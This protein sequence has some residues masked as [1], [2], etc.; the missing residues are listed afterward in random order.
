MKSLKFQFILSHIIPVIITIPLI[1][2]A[3][4]YAMETNYILKDMKKT[5]EDQ[6]NLIKDYSEK[7]PEIWKDDASANAFIQEIRPH[8]ITGVILFDKAWNMI[9][10]SDNGMVNLDTDLDQSQIVT[11]LGKNNFEPIL[12]VSRYNPFRKNDDIIEMMVPVSNDQNELLGIVRL[13]FPVNYFE[14]QLKQTSNRIVIILIC[15]ILL[16]ITMGLF[17]AIQLEKQ[18]KR[19]TNAIYDLSTGV[20]NNPLPETGSTEIRQLSVAFNKLAE[21]L[22]TSEQTRT[23]LISYLT[24]ELGRP[25]GALSSAVDS[26]YL[27]ASQDE[28]LAQ[29]LTTGMKN[30]IKRLELLVGDLSILREESDP[31]NQFFFK[32]V[33]L[34]EWLT[35][36]CK[37]WSEFAHSNEVNLINQ[38]SE[39]LPYFEM[40][41]N[42]F[43]QAIGNLLSNAIKYS[44]KGG[45]VILRASVISNEIQIAVIDFGPGISEVDQPHIFE[46]FYRGTEK[47]RF[48]QGMGLGLTIAKEV[49]EAHRGIITVESIA[50]KGSTFTIHLP[51][52]PDSSETFSE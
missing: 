3:L 15:G 24:H 35:N 28:K 50:G 7:N 14:E 49:V 12:N 36:I 32:P 40:D 19:T 52:L 13:N 20:R 25:L 44:L 34:S 48:I 30:E 23:K 39:N 18:L 22:E 42:R 6:A 27:G 9:A 5:I 31:L 4:S 26:L 2:V 1:A 51:L 11:T 41:V 21:K 33:N 43:H 47:K 8:L 45:N 46:M 16:G 29:D 17:N 38:V 10:I 37:Y